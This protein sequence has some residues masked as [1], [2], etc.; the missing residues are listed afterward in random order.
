MSDGTELDTVAFSNGVAY[1]TTADTTLTSL[2][3]YGYVFLRKLVGITGSYN[4]PATTSTLPSSDYHFVQNN[5]TIDKATRGVRADLLPD[6]SSP[7][8]L[9]SNGTLTDGVIAH[10]ES[11]AGLSLAQMVRDG[12]LSAYTVTIDPAQNVISTNTLTVA[13]KL[14]PVGV[15]DFITINIGFTTK[16]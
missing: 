4:T 16:L 14:L 5:R 8:T 6:L 10:F 3:N 1:S 11:Q 9:N 13:V 15:A 12:E 7:I 2:N